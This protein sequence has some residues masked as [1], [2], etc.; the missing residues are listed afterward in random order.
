MIF[1]SLC[2]LIKE[3]LLVPTVHV[4]GG[5]AILP[6]GIYKQPVLFVR[7]LVDPSSD[8]EKICK[9]IRV[10]ENGIH[11]LHYGAWKLITYAFV[12]DSYT[13]SYLRNVYH[14]CGDEAAGSV[15]LV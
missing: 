15:T 9:L 13:R 1:L 14:N 10:F 3:R 11:V 12:N 8:R 2:A 6:T 4:M 5:T 7:H